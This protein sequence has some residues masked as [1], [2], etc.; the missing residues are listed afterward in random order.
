M[1]SSNKNFTLIAQGIQGLKNAST[2]E[3]LQPFRLKK[4]EKRLSEELRE[5]ISTMLK[6]N[7][8]IHMRNSNDISGY[9]TKLQESGDK[10]MASGIM[11]T[12]TYN[13]VGNNASH[14]VNS[15]LTSSLNQLG[16]INQ[17]NNERI[18]S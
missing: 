12:N 5:H 7:N 4:D 18:D 2:L 6:L 10:A 17:T 15:S 1:L 14:N 9:G 11:K 3:I 16:H 8:Q 13:T